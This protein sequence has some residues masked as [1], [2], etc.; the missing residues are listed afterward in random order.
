[1]SVSPKRESWYSTQK[2]KNPR[3]MC[4]E[5][6]PFHFLSYKT[7]KP[8][9]KSTNTL[10]TQITN[11]LVTLNF[12]HPISLKN[13]RPSS[14]SSVPLL[15]STRFSRF[16]FE[17]EPVKKYQDQGNLETTM[18]EKRTRDVMEGLEQEV[19]EQHKRY[20]PETFTC[21]RRES[22][23]L[24][25]LTM[26]RQRTASNVAANGMVE[27]LANKGTAALNKAAPNGLVALYDSEEEERGRATNRAHATRSAFITPIP[28]PPTPKEVCRVYF[29]P[30]LDETPV[31][32][33]PSLQPWSQMHCTKDRALFG[34]KPASGEDIGSSSPSTKRNT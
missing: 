34:P 7:P 17:R 5:L 24:L 19:L 29:A 3:G 26:L 33:P 12:V 4:Q 8:N 13:A 22:G 30:I 18:A 16:F 6:L 25:S 2:L 1:M 28:A 23:H 11:S 20:G 15:P 21:T 14:G 27:Q 31:T 10:F 9:T 32:Q